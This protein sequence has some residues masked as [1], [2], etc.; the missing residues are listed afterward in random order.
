MKKTGDS[1]I[2]VETTIQLPAEKV[3]ELWTA[4]EHITNW[5]FASDDWQCPHAEN[6]LRPGGQF[7][8]RMEA[9]DGSMGFDFSGVY[10]EVDPYQ[11]I[12]YTMDDGRKV[13]IR[14]LEDGDETK[15]IETFESENTHT[16]G[17]QKKG[18]QSILNNFRSY[19]ESER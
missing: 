9:I 5:N 19:A 12:A 8:S 6:D 17:E 18:W 2:T 10:D 13:T 15:I 11:L 3:W 7:S 4:P 16:A 1:K 14:F